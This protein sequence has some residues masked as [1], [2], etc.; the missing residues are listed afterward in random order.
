MGVLV[1]IVIVGVVSEKLLRLLKLLRL[2]EG[3]VCLVVRVG[4]PAMVG[5]AE[6]PTMRAKATEKKLDGFIVIVVRCSKL[7]KNLRKYNK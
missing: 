3:G 6:A 1:G 4:M 5:C 2:R 7:K